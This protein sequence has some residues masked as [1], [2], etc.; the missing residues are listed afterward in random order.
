MVFA[1]G[2]A[3]VCRPGIN[4]HH[5]GVVRSAQIRSA[6]VWCILNLGGKNV[7]Q[8][9]LKTY[10]LNGYSYLNTP[11]SIHLR[12][13]QDPW[14]IRCPYWASLSNNGGYWNVMIMD[15]TQRDH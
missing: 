2:M 1:N 11:R 4:N 7:P 3:T 14:D 12:P 5:A 9:F 6:L 10:V 13:I 15:Y 8:E